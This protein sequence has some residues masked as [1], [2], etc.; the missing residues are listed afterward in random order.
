MDHSDLAGEKDSYIQCGHGRCLDH[1]PEWENVGNVRREPNP[2][3]F[4]QKTYWFTHCCGA[5]MARYKNVQT[6]RCQKCGRQEDHITYD[7]LALCL[8]CGRHSRLSY[9]V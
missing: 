4:G 9:R 7:H 5:P 1:G 6:K 8:C 2:G 3:I